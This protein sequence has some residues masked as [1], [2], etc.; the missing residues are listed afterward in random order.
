MNRTYIIIGL[1]AIF[2]F[3]AGAVVPPCSSASPGWTFASLGYCGNDS[4]GV[5]FTASNGQQITIFPEL[6]K[7]G[8]VQSNTSWDSNG[9]D[10]LFEVQKGHDGNIASGIAPY[11][12]G[13]GTSPFLG[14]QG[15][16]DFDSGGH[17]YDIM[18]FIEIQGGTGAGQIPTGTTLS[19]LLQQG[20]QALDNVDA[21]WGAF[22]SGQTTPPNISAF[23]NSTNFD[24][25]HANGGNTV[26]QFSLQTSTDASHPIEWIAIRD[27]CTYL[28][29]N[30]ITETSYVP[31]PRFYGLMMAGLLGV[32]GIYARKR[33]IAEQQS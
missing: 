6:L 26:P 21:Y 31:E 12:T 30:S 20:D 10:G 16:T 15:I 2:S 25:L 13:E 7:D 9:I 4:S 32:A 5:T 23:S 33:R 11:V 27:D 22:G 29:L 24:L 8:N 3:T 14:Q 19:F 18:L 1:L 17:H 28:L